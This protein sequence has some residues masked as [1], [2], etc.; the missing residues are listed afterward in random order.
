M[1]I[2]GQLVEHSVDRNISTALY[3]TLT[4]TLPWLT[5]P[6]L[7]LPCIAL[8]CLVLSYLTLPYLTL[9]YLALTYP[10][11]PLPCLT[12]PH[13]T[14]PYPGP[15]PSPYELAGCDGVGEAEDGP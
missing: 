1:N 8:P 4:P 12:L 14:L 15:L 5:F 9:P 7:T 3:P 13:P 2:S 6:Y 11:L 10:T